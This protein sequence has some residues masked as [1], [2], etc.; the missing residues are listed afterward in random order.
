MNTFQ[1]DN[2]SSPMFLQHL[3]GDYVFII[4]VV[5]LLLFFVFTYFKVPETKGRTFDDIAAGFR[6]TAA[7]GVKHSPEELNSLGADSQL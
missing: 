5:L 4:F 1:C 3:C 7:G 6:Q 2:C